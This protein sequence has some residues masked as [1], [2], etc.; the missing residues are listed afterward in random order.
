MIYLAN[1]DEV[2]TISGLGVWPAAASVE[3]FLDKHAGAIPEG[4]LRTVVPAAPDAWITALERYGTLSF[5]DAAAEAIRFAR[6]GFI[7]YP[8]MQ[9]VMASCSDDYARWPENKAIYLPNG[10]T[11]EVGELFVQTDLGQ[12]ASVHGR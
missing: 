8:L 3:L 11:P 5:G 2:V 4:L 1:T 10:R 12:D 9:K 7:T 6:D